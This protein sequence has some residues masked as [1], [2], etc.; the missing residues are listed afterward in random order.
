VG[1]KDNEKLR[2]F[3]FQDAYGVD[4]K[5]DGTD[6]D[7]K[8]GTDGLVNF[9][10]RENPLSDFQPGMNALSVSRVYYHRPGDWR[11][12]PNFFNPFWGAKLHP[13]AHHQVLDM[14]HVGGLL[15]EVVTH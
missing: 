1:S 3:F 10:Q 8:E 11:E 15:D 13:V 4:F 12:H 2:K 5:V 7:T 14:I 6:I 9:E